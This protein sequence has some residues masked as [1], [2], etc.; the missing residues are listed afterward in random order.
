MPVIT[1]HRKLTW[2]PSDITIVKEAVSMALLCL[3]E[4][5]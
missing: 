4:Y 1:L 3:L 2:I 5:L